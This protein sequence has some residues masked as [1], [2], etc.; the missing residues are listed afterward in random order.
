MTLQE[1]CE[2]AIKKG[3]T[4]NPETGYIF[5]VK[6]GI[7]KRTHHSGYIEF[8]IKEDGKEYSIR[9]HQ[10][11]WYWV[12]KECVYCID[13]RNRIRNDNRILN[14]RSVT[15]KENSY[16]TKNGES[17]GVT[18]NKKSQKWY[19]QIGV[20]YKRLHLGSFDTKEEARESYLKGRE[21]YFN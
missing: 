2:L 16:N 9:G 8:K 20:D 18:F 1:K 13:H 17:Q 3:F 14:L 11:A 10:F 21:K 5:G 19:A 12:Y 4:Y 6:G 15:R 7:V